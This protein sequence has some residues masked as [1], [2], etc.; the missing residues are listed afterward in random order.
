MTFE[1]ADCGETV[2]FDPVPDILDEDVCRPCA[3]QR[4]PTDTRWGVTD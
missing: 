4:A 2:P 3:S 1:C